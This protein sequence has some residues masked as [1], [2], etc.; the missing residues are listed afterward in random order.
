MKP[1]PALSINLP[2][3]EE[4][5]F[6]VLRQAEE[7]IS[8]IGQK[9]GKGSDEFKNSCRKLLEATMGGKGN[10]I[11][12]F[13]RNSIDVRAFAYLAG[14]STEF[15]E[16]IRISRTLLDHLLIIKSPVTRLTLTQ[17]IRAFFVNF[18]VFL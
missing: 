5:H 8:A 4:K 9:A 16:S 6:S 14:T 12:R 15:S 7:R 18:N 10:V 2:E 1:L 17:L 3:W 13:I 11:H